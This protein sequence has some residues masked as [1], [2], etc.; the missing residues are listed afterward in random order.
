MTCRLSRGALLAILATANLACVAGPRFTQCPG[1]GGRAWM[2]LDSEHY[3]LRTDLPP[4]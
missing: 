4:V 2:E 1:D 3:A